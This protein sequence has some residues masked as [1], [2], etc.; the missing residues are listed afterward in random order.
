MSEPGTR[1]GGLTALAVINFI[2]AALGIIGAIG[3]MAAP[4]FVKMATKHHEEVEA[5]DAAKA[6]ADSRVIEDG[7]PDT[8]AREERR[9]QNE[10][11][12]EA[13]RKMEKIPHYYFIISGVVALAIAILELLSGI[14]YLKLKRFLGKTLG[15]TYALVA[16]GW[17]A[18]EVLYANK[19]LGQEFGLLN[20]IGFIYPLITLW[21]LRSVFKDDFVNP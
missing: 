9:K 16:I 6:A 19:L 8:R 7:D 17:G 1:P 4:T 3:T 15:T 11:M 21:C 12:Q 18:V 10:E 14:G 13:V 2:F 5:R 20:M